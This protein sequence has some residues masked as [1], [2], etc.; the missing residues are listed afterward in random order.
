[1]KDTPKKRVPRM[2]IS[3][4]PDEKDGNDP[5][6]RVVYQIDVNA[7]NPVEAALDA[8]RLMVDP[9]SMAPILTVIASD[10]EQIEVD[11]EKGTST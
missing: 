10:G 11:L 2:T 6:F 8:Y 4:P 3:P 7:A 5:L 1:M 9:A